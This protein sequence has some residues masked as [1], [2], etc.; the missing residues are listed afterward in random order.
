M[1]GRLGLELAR[2]GALVVSGLAQGVDAA[3][4]KG[5]LQGGGTVVSVLGGGVDVPYPPQNRGLYE[6]VMAAGCVLSEYPPGTDL[7]GMALPRPQPD[8]SAGCRW[9]WW[10]WRPPS[11][12][13][14]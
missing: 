1:A 4:L 5:A 9:A 2:G 10:R 7:G 13:A 8:S 11:T 12:A 6:D 14:P 3:S